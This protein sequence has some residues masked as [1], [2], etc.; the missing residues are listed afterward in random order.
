MKLSARNQ[1]KG[2]IVAAVF[3]L[4]ALAPVAGETAADRAQPLL[5]ERRPI[6]WRWRAR[7]FDSDRFEPG[8]VALPRDRSAAEQR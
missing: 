2:K 5:T 8:R 7:Q 3:P 6:G 4:P 1:L